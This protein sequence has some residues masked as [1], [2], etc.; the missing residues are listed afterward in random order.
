MAEVTVVSA[1]DRISTTSFVFGCQGEGPWSTRVLC[2]SLRSSSALRSA[3][4]Q[5]TQLRHPRERT[6][7]MHLPPFQIHYIH[8]DEHVSNQIRQAPGDVRVSDARIGLLPQ[9]RE[10]YA[11]SSRLR[12]ERL[13]TPERAG[14]AAN[15]K[16]IFGMGSARSHSVP[17]WRPLSHHW[18]SVGGCHAARQITSPGALFAGRSSM[19]RPDVWSQNVR[20]TRV[21][22]RREPAQVSARVSSTHLRGGLW[23]HQAPL[24]SVGCRPPIGLPA[25]ADASG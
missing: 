21:P 4:R 6:R 17:G 23:R 12:R 8:D 25:R 7:D 9:Q 14:K 10:G 3:S 18:R 2:S 15:L 20:A 5:A 11:Q 13:L 19:S 1:A 24:G 16:E 22:C